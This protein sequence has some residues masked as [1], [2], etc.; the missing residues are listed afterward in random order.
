MALN[1]AQL[2]IKSIDLGSNAKITDKQQYINSNSAAA[3]TTAA[4][5][6]SRCCLHT[7]TIKLISFRFLTLTV[8]SRSSSATTTFPVSP[9]SR[10]PG[11]DPGSV[12][13][14]VPPPTSARRRHCCRRHV[15][16]P[17]TAGT[18]SSVPAGPPV[19]AAWIPLGE[20]PATRTHARA[21]F[22]R[23]RRHDSNIVKD[24]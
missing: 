4:T 8:E 15:T 14:L 21:R 9:C 19:P 11:S 10:R 17:R 3:V 12:L 2:V 20:A 18:V 5:R 13:I 1:P 24:L 6:W 7:Q 23:Q 22:S 16:G